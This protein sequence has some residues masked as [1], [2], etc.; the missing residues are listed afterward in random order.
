[1]HLDSRMHSISLNVHTGTP[2]LASK[3]HAARRYSCMLL[4]YSR[5]AFSTSACLSSTPATNSAD[6]DD[7]DNGN[8]GSGNDGDGGR[9]LPLPVPLLLLLMLFLVWSAA[10]AAATKSPVRTI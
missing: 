10:A 1:M 4:C 7:D 9:W 5:R 6:G 3:R 8:G 2:H